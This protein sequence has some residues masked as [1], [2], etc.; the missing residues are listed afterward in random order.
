M[1]VI[2]VEHNSN[3][4]TICNYHLRD[5]NISLKAKGLLTYMLSLP[6]DWDY[7]ISGLSKVSKEGIDSIRSAIIELENYGYMYR[8]RVRNDDGTLGGSE[9]VVREIP[10]Q[11]FPSKDEPMVEN[12]TQDNTTQLITNIQNN[13]ETK[14]L[15]NKRTNYS[16]KSKFVVP[17]VDEVRFYCQERNNNIDPETFIDFYESK[18][19][20]VGRNKMKDWKAAIRTWEKGGKDNGRTNQTQGCSTTE[21]KPSERYASTFASL[22]HA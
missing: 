15:T 4:T 7:S 1:S 12:P 2:R 21:Q 9:Y 18:G 13:E 3:Y 14:K 22:R 11:N 5:K 6:D 19:W 17:T 16:R 10:M 20:M 8:A